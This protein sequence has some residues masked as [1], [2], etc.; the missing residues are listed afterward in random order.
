MPNFD[1]IGN[2]FGKIIDT[3]AGSLAAVIA[4]LGVVM[5]ANVYSVL[6]NKMKQVDPAADVQAA[7]DAEFVKTVLPIAEVRDEIA[8]EIAE[9]TYTREDI[10]RIAAWQ[11]GLEILSDVDERKLEYMTVRDAHR[12]LK[13]NE[14]I[15]GSVRNMLWLGIITKSDAKKVRRQGSQEKQID[16]LDSILK[17]KKRVDADLI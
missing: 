6:G 15:R 2:Q 9:T 11:K 10:E 3:K 14:D 8:D 1:Q 12:W 13:N 16:M 17:K 4:V 5:G 7:E